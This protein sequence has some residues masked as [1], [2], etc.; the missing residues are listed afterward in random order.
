MGFAPRSFFRSFTLLY[1][2]MNAI[3]AS[4]QERLPL[5]SGW[6]IQLSAKVQDTGDVI[7]TAKFHATDWTPISVP[8]TV[9]SAFVQNKTYPDPYYGKNLREL[10]GMTYEIG[11]NFANEPMDPSSPFAVP[12]WY[13]TEFRLPATFSGKSVALHF[14]GINYRAN[15]W[16]NGQKIASSDEV[17]GAW[18]I[19]EF[20]VTKF[21]KP[22]VNT[23]AAEIFAPKENDLGITFVDWNPTPPDKNLGLFRPVYLTMSGPVTLRHAQVRSKVAADAKSAELTLDVDVHNT[24][25]KPVRG[26]LRGT[27]GTIPFSA[28][29]DL[30]PGETKDLELTSKEVREFAVKNP[31]LWWPAQIGTPALHDLQVSFLINGAV[32]DSLKEKFGI[33]E[34]TS[35]MNPQQQLMFRVNG[36]P[37]LI[38]GGGWATDMML[39]FDPKRTEREV[40]YAQDMG[41]NTIRLE[42]KLEPKEFFDLT[43]RLG[44]LVMAGWC[45][46]DH[47]EKWENW[48]PAD[49]KIAE[50][51]AV[52][53]IKRLR[54]HPSLLVWL[55]GSDNP[56]PAE[57]EK[58]YLDAEMRCKWPNPTLSSATANPA[59]FSGA[60]GVK[61]TGPYD[62]VPPDYWSSDPG[63]FG[64]AWGF[65]TETSPGPAIPP[66]ESMRA[67]LPKEHQW[68]PD[69]WWDFHAGGGQFKDINIYKDAMAQ[70]YGPSD[71]LDQFTMKAQ[72]MNY[73]GIRAM[74]EAFGENKYKS[75]GVIQWMM[76]NG[77]PSTIWHL[78]DWYLRPGG[79]Y[80]GAKKATEPLHAQYSPKDGSLWIVNS[81]YADAAG[82]KL[83]AQTLALDGS[84]KTQKQFT[85]D[86]KAD[87]ANRVTDALA[88]DGDGAYFLSLRLTDKAGKLLS[89]NFYWLSAKPDT[90]DWDKSTWYFT[91]TTSYADFKALDS[92]PKVKLQYSSTS[93]RSGDKVHTTVKIKNP[94][95]NV[96]FLVRLKANKGGEEILPVLWQ[97]NY[98]SLLPGEAREITA[99]HDAADVGAGKITVT[100]QGWNSQ[101]E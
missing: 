9:V 52:D 50:L 38:R 42:G 73:E 79:G 2:A 6:A 68:P 92:M 95:K 90:L 40:R 29:V 72:A 44:I 43:D 81:T 27:A 48:K 94:S 60:S 10:P 17:A 88:V 39:R 66:A 21:V 98:F 19:Y 7:S 47:W 85:A 22:G 89:S 77:W 82:L 35:E 76:N 54:A 71:T 23:L 56:P 75:T 8:N 33:R 13:R 30:A 18:R 16:L 91:P 83:T 93:V 97:D 51:S 45:C 26:T 3:A 58:V 25:D 46:C 86:V 57:V 34:I 64:G 32:S 74:F 84:A 99:T 1:V 87:S 63:K 65:N 11:K 15:I 55:N 61:M 67:M 24:T 4:A 80:F 20:D 53:Q 96:A 12:W 62:Y 41:F 37:I 70:R 36:K 100:A 69:D 59:H 49:H 31:Q 14:D 28:K 5:Q 101:A 78:Y